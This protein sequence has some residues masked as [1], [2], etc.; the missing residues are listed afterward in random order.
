MQLGDECCYRMTDDA[1][2]TEARLQ[3][4]RD[5]VDD[6]FQWHWQLEECGF[7]LNLVWSVGRS[8][9][10]SACPFPSLIP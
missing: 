6:D 7:G 8:V 5:V 3:L 2:V 9:G 10:R 4:M 1:A